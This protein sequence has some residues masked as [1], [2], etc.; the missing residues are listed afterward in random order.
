MKNILT[1]ILITFALLHGLMFGAANDLKFTQKNAGNNA[2]VDRIFAP[3][4]G[5]E[6]TTLPLFRGSLG[7]A[8]TI[9]TS[10]TCTSDADLSM[11]SVSFGTDQTAKLQAILD[12]ASSGPIIV[13]WDG[14]YSVTG[15]RVRSNTRII[16]LPGCGAILRTASNLPIFRNQ[17]RTISTIVDHD[18]FID[19]G[20]WNGNGLN[21]SSHNSTEGWITEFCFMGIDQLTI[22]NTIHR[23]PA[24]FTIF[25]SNFSNVKLEDIYIDV[26]NS[27]TTNMDGIHFNGPGQ[28]IVVKNLVASC[29]DDA[30]SISP[31][32][33][34]ALGAFGGVYGAGAGVGGFQPYGDIKNVLIDGLTLLPYSRNGIR[35]YSSAN[36][37]DN[38]TIRNVKGECINWWLC[39]DNLVPFQ[40]YNFPPGPGYVGTVLVDGAS[41][42]VSASDFH[43]THIYVSCNLDQL[44]LRNIAR[45]FYNTASTP[46]VLIDNAA[47]VTNMTIEGFSTNPTSGTNTGS[48]IL[49][50]GTVTNLSFAGNSFMNYSGGT[51]GCPVTFAA[52]SVVTKL[53]LGI[54][55][56]TGFSGLL[57]NLGTISARSDFESLTGNDATLNGVSTTQPLTIVASATSQVGGGIEY[58]SSAGASKWRLGLY[59]FAGTETSNLIYSYFNGSAWSDQLTL[60]SAGA[61]TD[62]AITSPLF[63]QGSP[64]L[65]SASG[66]WVK[67]STSGTF[68]SGMTLQRTDTAD[69][70]AAVMGGDNKLYFGY[71]TNASGADA[72][73]DWT[74]KASLDS[75]G[76]F[77]P[78]TAMAA[79]SGGTGQSTYT[80]GDTLAASSSSALAKVSTGATGT[81]LTSNG[82]GVLPSYQAVGAGNSSYSTYAA[83]TAYSLTASDAA[84]D[85]GTTDP[86]I[87]ITNAGRYLILSRAYLKYNAATYAGNQTATVHLQRTNNTPAAITNAT[88]TATLRILTT[89]TDTVGIMEI[90]AVV[91]TATAGDVITIYGALSATPSAGSIDATEASVV[92]IPF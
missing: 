16:A 36:R 5:T 50:N 76:N 1:K 41:V 83:G 72:T 59:G 29:R 80:I 73:G 67:Q 60:T 44:L 14:A 24:S 53:N 45:N 79:T 84:L 55:L 62:L 89:I 92:A 63:A 69:S 39:I 88:T 68:G 37:A 71:A 77:V 31:N 22:K 10:T 2:W 40:A 15:L 32:D 18:I 13:I 66:L 75:S 9:N 49:V 3:A 7:F 25:G 35:I 82:V 46:T 78:A 20:I 58:K 65:A 86:T 8:Q 61:T 51:T 74:I 27:G 30:I 21:Q 4:S 64:T 42:N 70:W 26:G 91:Y 28:D 6:A 81:V 43:N 90:P 11:Y 52:G 87:T 34:W 56:V 85:F 23:N 54:N 57:N 33:G 17:N 38:Y 47:V 19:G 48:Q 12:M